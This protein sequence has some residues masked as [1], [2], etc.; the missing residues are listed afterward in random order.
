[1]NKQDTRLTRMRN[2]CN[3]YSLFFIRPTSSSNVH[4]SAKELMQIETVQE[5]M[6][7]SGRYGFVVKC[8]SENKSEQKVSSYIKKRYGNVNVSKLE[9]HYQ[10]LR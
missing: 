7:T 6:I 5:V 3:G 9:C 4:D 1:M 8:P 2:R 10:Y